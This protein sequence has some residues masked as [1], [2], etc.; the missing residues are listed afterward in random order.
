MHGVP[1]NLGLLALARFEV[2]HK[3]QRARKQASKQEQRSIFG[4][5]NRP[6]TA[7]CNP[8]ISGPSSYVG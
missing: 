7:T 1:S 4:I 8:A 6:L 2:A 5:K 3:R